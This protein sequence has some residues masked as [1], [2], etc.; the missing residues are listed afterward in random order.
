V[1]DIFS[2]ALSLEEN[3]CFQD[4]LKL[5]WEISKL[6]PAKFALGIAINHNRSIH[7]ISLSQTAFID[8][9]IERF[10]QVDAHP[11]DIQMVTELQLYC[12]NLSISP[13]QKCLP[14]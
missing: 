7:T 1:D 8:C 10:G 3:N 12:P 13:P 5:H 2:A 4:I 14:G 11:C 6:G 9:M